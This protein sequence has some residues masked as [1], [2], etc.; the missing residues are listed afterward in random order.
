MEVIIIIL[1]VIGMV[2]FLFSDKPGDRLKWD[3]EGIRYMHRSRF[4]DGFRSL[5]KVVVFFVLIAF[6]LACCSYM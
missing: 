6:I 4:A 2:K 5:A 1:I 3:K